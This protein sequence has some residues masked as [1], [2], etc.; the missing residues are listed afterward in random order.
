MV[1]SSPLDELRYLLDTKPFSH[2]I[3]DFCSTTHNLDSFLSSFLRYKQNNVKNSMKMLQSY[4]SFRSEK[5]GNNRLSAADVRCPLL[6]KFL[7]IPDST[8]VDGRQ[9]VIIFFDRILEH[10]LSEAE[11]LKTLWFFLENMMDMPVCQEKGIC[12][13][14]IF[15]NSMSSR[16]KGLVELVFES[17]QNKV[18]VK[19]GSVFLLNPPPWLRFFWAVSSNFMKSKLVRRVK[20]FSGDYQAQLIELIGKENLIKELGGDLQLDHDEWICAFYPDLNLDDIARSGRILYSTLSG[21]ITSLVDSK[22]D[23]ACQ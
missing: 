19:L 17:I 3:H 10:R 23:I 11:I 4:W 13:I 15:G 5:I 20:L 16:S 1:D 2:E 8:D 7:Y 6:S 18:P 12:L 22:V 14:S 21:S 9:I